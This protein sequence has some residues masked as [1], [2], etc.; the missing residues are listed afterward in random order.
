MNCCPNSTYFLTDSFEIQC[1]ICP[2]NA[3]EQLLSSKE[4]GRLKAI[5]Y[6]KAND[7]LSLFFTFFL[8]FVSNK[9]WE[10]FTKVCCVIMS[11]IKIG[12]VK[13]IL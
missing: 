13:A 5:L 6:S 11:S 12:L 7:I 2:C 4:I 1:G 10:M 9:V 3:I 8:L